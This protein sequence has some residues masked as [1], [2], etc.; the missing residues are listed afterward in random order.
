MRAVVLAAGPGRRLRPLTHT[1]PKHLIPI[2]GKPILQYGLESLKKAGFTELAI[3]VGHMKE[4]IIDYLR[5]GSK[6]GVKITYIPQEN[7]KGIA[8]AIMQARDYVGEEPFVVYLGDNLLRNGIQ[9]YVSTFNEHES[10]A[11][12]L[13]CHV[14]SPERFGVAEVEGSRVIRLE[15]KPRVPKSDLALV[16]VYFLTHRIF[17]AISNLTPSWR[18][19]LEITDALQK[20]VSTG[21]KVGFSV[22]NGWWAD[23]GR[24]ED[25][26]EAT[27]LVLDGIESDIKGEIHESVQ[28]SGRVTIGAGT[29]IH[30]GTRLRGPLYIGRN[31][32]IGPNTYVGPYTS[33]EDRCTI[34]GGEIENT[35]V[36]GD[37]H[38]EL[39]RANRIVDSLIGSNSSVVADEG[40]KPRGARLV[41]GDNSYL[42]I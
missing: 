25:L 20:L 15:E 9:E 34:K 27:A 3:V 4:Q 5:D 29:F 30:E 11:S 16:G 1:G 12:V 24:P 35:V 33:I 2:A 14:R 23:S 38:I 18:G 36:L 42:A 32:I 8:D 41:V 6:L 7:Q 10:D 21:H 40:L 37:C 39:S 22:V 26:I 17:D 28:V 19:E 13:L 31:C